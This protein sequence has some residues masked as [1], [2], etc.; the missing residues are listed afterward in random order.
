[1][2]TYIHTRRCRQ[3]ETV[4][5]LGWTAL[6]LSV[7]AILA[8]CCAYHSHRRTVRTSSFLHFP[9]PPFFPSSFLPSS[10]LYSEQTPD[11]EWIHA[12]PW[13]SSRIIAVP[14]RT[15]SPYRSQYTNSISLS[16]F[17]VPNRGSNRLYSPRHPNRRIEDWCYPCSV[18]ASQTSFICN[19]NSQLVVLLFCVSQIYLS[20][21]KGRSST[22]L[23]SGVHP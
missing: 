13:N 12:A 23:N 9:P 18:F 16:P 14:I 6:G 21:I 10:R 17:R 11:P 3:L 19:Y 2:F 20:D 4:E 7:I 15:A 5:A 8:G 1:M 22:N